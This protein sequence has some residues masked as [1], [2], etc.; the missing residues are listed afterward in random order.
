MNAGTKVEIIKGCRD[1]NIHKGWV[2]TVERAGPTGDGGAFVRLSFDLRGATFR[3]TL[4]TSA[5]GKL[6]REEFTLNNG[7]PLKSIKVRVVSR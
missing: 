7:N 3:K 6:A 1:F 4:Y 2:A 5:A